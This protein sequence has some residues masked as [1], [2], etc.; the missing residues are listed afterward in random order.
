MNNKL[1]GI[2]F[3]LKKV[4]DNDLFIKILSST[5]EINT[6]MVYGGNSTKKKSTY[7][8]GYFIEYSVSK[9]NQSSPPIFTAETSKPYLGN[10]FTDKY[11]MNALLSVLS[12]INL[13][14]VEGQNIKGFYYD[15]ESLIYNIIKNNH[16]IVFYCEWLFNLLQKIGYQIDYK[17]NNKYE[18][19]NISKQEF[20]N[21]FDK[22][23]LKFP[24]L[25]FSESHEVNFKNI[26]TVFIIFESI[27]L[28]NHLDDVN[29][30]IPGNFINF[31]NMIL[32]RLKS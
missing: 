7:Q 24:H 10:V 22:N 15:V 25:L 4:K 19:Y 1:K 30:R 8:N 2:I 14:I 28:K 18:F 5:D 6:G 32:N 11:K 31:K 21:K 26:N 29:Y 3:Y 20:N 13:S 12:L 23:S 9:K 16:W 17:K 27:F